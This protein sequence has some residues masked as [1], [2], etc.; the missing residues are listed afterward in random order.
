MYI[1]CHHIV[2]FVVVVVFVYE[3]FWELGFTLEHIYMYK[4]FLCLYFFK[5]LL[6]SPFLGNYNGIQEREG[7][8]LLFSMLISTNLAAFYSCL[9]WH[10][11]SYDFTIVFEI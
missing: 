1:Y 11:L 10:L 9:T 4:V 2:F 5:N 8:L 7:L 3:G 6:I